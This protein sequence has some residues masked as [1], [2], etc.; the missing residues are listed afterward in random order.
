MSSKPKADWMHLETSDVIR[1]LGLQT[2]R[3]TEAELGRPSSLSAAV[4][5]GDETRVVDWPE[6]SPQCR[7]GLAH[8]CKPSD[9]MVVVFR[10]LKA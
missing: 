10:S 4:Q 9:D 5:R 7:S 6:A 3:E 2:R 1:R 8:V